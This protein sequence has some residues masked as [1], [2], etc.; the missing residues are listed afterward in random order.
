VLRDAVIVAGAVAYR[1]VV[2]HI[3]MAPTRL[4][5]ANTFIEFGVLTLA[6]AQAGGL[7]GVEPWLL[8]L[9]VLL[10]ASVLVSGAHYVWVWRRKAIRDAGGNA[11]ENN[12]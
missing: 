2:G 4:S 1:F 10:F 9:F 5:K 6:L 11:S 8:P 3:E 12:S 7:V